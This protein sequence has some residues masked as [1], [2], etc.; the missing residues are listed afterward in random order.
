MMSANNELNK[1]ETLGS[2]NHDDESTEDEPNHA[3]AL[4]VLEM[5]TES[6]TEEPKDFKLKE[7][8]KILCS[9]FTYEKLWR[10]RTWSD[11]GKHFA[12]SLGTALIPSTYDTVTDSL[13]C[14]DF[15]FGKD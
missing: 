4:Q 3:T 11:I 15:W 1:K 5:E 14:Y 10:N 8:F 6:S 12:L 2:E 7:Y 13:L 9:E